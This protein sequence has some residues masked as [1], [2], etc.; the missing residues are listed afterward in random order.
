MNQ[1]W[2]RIFSRY[3]SPV[4]AWILSACALFALPSTV[5]ANDRKQVNHQ[6]AILAVP[7]EGAYTGAYI[8]FGEFEDDVSLEA[9]EKFDKLVGKRQAIIGYSSFWGRES[10]PRDALNIVHSYGAVSLIYWNPWDGHGKSTP[11]RFNLDAILAGKWDPYI[12][13]WARGAKE[14]GHPML[15][16]WGLEM[17]GNWF[18]WSGIFAGGGKLLQ[19]EPVKKYKGPEVFKKA[20]RY[21]VDRVRAAGASNIQWV[22]HPNNSADPNE[23]WNI[24]K[25]YYPGDNYADWLAY[26]AYGKQYPGPGW[27]PFEDVLPPY[28]QALADLHPTKPILLA[29]WG[30]GEF[31][32]QGDKGAWIKDAFTGFKSRFPRIKGAVF[33]HE[34]WQNGDLTYSN[35][36]VNSSRGALRAYQ[37]GVSDP[38]WMD[39]PRW[40]YEVSSTGE[41]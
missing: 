35:L 4:A 20:Y 5:Q 14:F 19:S 15:V 32:K 41:K 30:I 2:L 38:Y 22:F 34:R 1:R 10:F 27:E 25:E 37:D 18:P 7:S 21:V 31:P 17:N 11:N 9:I 23:P 36:R 39:R 12:D 28:F 6:K 40:S 16:S 13:V 8:D 3:R 29:E 33:W 24:I 26:S